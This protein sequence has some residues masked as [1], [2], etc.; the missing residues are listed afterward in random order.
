MRLEF[1]SC[2]ILFLCCTLS[3]TE[4]FRFKGNQRSPVILGK[5]AF[6]YQSYEQIVQKSRKFLL[7]INLV[8]G[9]GGNQI[10]AKLNKTSA[11]HYLCQKKTADFF[12]IWLNLELLVPVIIDCWVI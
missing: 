4:T 9:D 6:F 1:G 5:F 2:I 8:P 3:V 10:D 11:V 12:N 7:N